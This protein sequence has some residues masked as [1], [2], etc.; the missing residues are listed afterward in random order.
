MGPQRVADLA[1]ARLLLHLRR[2]ISGDRRHRASDL[3]PLPFCPL[4]HGAVLPAVLS[5]DRNGGL[6][7]PDER[8]PTRLYHR[9]KI[10]VT[11]RAGRRC[12]TRRNAAILGQSPTLRGIETG[13]D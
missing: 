1:T 11:D 2:D 9:W 4:P 5:P 6:H 7:A 13:G 12:S 3:R 10:P 8:V